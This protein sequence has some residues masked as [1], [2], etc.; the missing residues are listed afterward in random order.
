MLI[1][2]TEGRTGLTFSVDL[3]LDTAQSGILDGSVTTL[4][5]DCQ[6]W[7][8][9][10]EISVHTVEQRIRTDGYRSSK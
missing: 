7:R 1:I 3:R 10:G 2:V 8:R 6:Y 9:V 5:Y 4:N